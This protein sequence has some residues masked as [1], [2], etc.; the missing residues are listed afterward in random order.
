MD[1]AFNKQFLSYFVLEAIIIDIENVIKF[2]L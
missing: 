2:S 1:T